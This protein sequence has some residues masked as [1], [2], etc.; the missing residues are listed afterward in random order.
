MNSASSRV[1]LLLSWLLLTGPL[2]A[3]DPATPSGP[4]SATVDQLVTEVLSQNPELRYYDA[5]LT[6]ARAQLKTAAQLPPPEINGSLGRKRTSDLAGTLAGEGTAW[7]AGVSQTF[8]WPGRLGLRKAIANRDMVLAGLGRARF[9]NAL[10]GRAR[11]LA[12]G[13]AAA[14]EQRRVAGEVAER[15]HALREV[16]VQRDPAGVAPA[17][18]I[19]ILEATELSL[20]R[21]AAK[22]DQEWNTLRT[23]LNL[24]RGR[25][26]DATLLLPWVEPT[27]GSSPKLE[28]V[29]AAAQTNNFDLRVRLVELEQQGFRVDLARNERWPAF[30]IG[31]HYS[32]ERSDAR[33]QLVGLSINFPLPLWRN[34]T[35]RT[36]AAQARRVQAESVLATAR[37]DLERRLTVAVNSYTALAAE[38]QRWRPDTVEQF[39][40][41]AELADRHYRLGAVPA[42]TYVEL[43]KQYTEAVDAWLE[44]RRE[45]IEHAQ[46]IEQLSGIPVLPASRTTAQPSTGATP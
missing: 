8:E 17:L 10:A 38:L 5:E 14:A 34:N 20:R 9:T 41:A 42:T 43:Q 29:L 37:R 1:R 26:A 21:K 27:L 12:F 19:R 7:S 31:T 33:D 25:P 32:E 35:A 3:A 13:V 28:A 39:R 6:A 44:T 40:A 23:E 46:E 18:E 30:T 45:A 36:E 4:P 11:S 2:R 16:L 22:A 24:L 15:F